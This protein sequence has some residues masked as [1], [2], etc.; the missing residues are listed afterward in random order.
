MTPF[1]RPHTLLRSRIV[2]LAALTLFSVVAPCHAGDVEVDKVKARIKAAI[3]A[4]TR[5]DLQRAL[6]ILEPLVQAKME[7]TQRVV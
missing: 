1:G 5:K 4:M 7:L 6:Q 3:L 2:L